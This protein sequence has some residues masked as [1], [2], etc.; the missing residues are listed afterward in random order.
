MCINYIVN[1][2]IQRMMEGSLVYFS[3][4]TKTY[5][6]CAYDNC[7]VKVMQMNTHNI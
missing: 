5:V 1:F 4:K 2:L 7:L 6:V 3:I